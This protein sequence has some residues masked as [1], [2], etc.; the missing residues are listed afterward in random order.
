MA[1]RIRKNIVVV[2]LVID[3]ISLVTSFFLAYYLR[4]FGP[5]RIFLNEIQPVQVYLLALPFAILLLVATFYVNGLYDL[6]ARATKNEVYL[7][8]KSSSIWTLLVMSGSYVAKYDYSRLIVVLTFIF[9]LLTTTIFRKVI[10]RY[11]Q[12]LF[13]NGKGL[14]NILIVGAGKTGRDLYN[15]LTVYSQAGYVIAG[16]IDDFVPSKNKYPVVGKL[17]D[18]KKVIKKYGIGE[19]YIAD[20]N[21][22]HRQI[23]DLAAK[24][25]GKDLSFKVISNVFSLVKESVDIA[26]LDSIPSLDLGKLDHGWGNSILKRSFDIIFSAV[27]TIAF[28]PVYLLIYIAILIADGSPALIKQKRVGEKGKNFYMY[29]F[30]TMKPSKN[31][32][33][34][35][36]KIER[37]SVTKLGKFLRS[38]SLDELPQL[39]NVIR[40]E[41]SLVGPRPEIPT[42]TKNYNSWQKLRFHAKPGITGLWQVLG[43]KD[44]PLENNLEYDFYY[45]NNRSLLL[46]IS[47]LLKTI[48]AVIS[49]KGAY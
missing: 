13:R 37:R 33:S 11:Q 43:R 9:L 2:L 46:D 25:K 23:L 32:K 49:G 26:N 14:L 1:N 30:R 8:A 35:L 24:F 10:D 31:I 40:G 48:S 3:S 41:M 42:K 20:S 21:L 18:I 19:V 44:L 12:N 15:R 16:F 22:S 47:I 7:T 34:E 6:K 36:K 17:K 45:I 28:S 38:S 29:K 27:L 5:F 4:N 39:I